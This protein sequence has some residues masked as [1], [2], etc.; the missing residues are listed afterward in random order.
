M[1]TLMQ[2]RH[3]GG[4]NGLRVSSLCLGTM[5]FGTRVSEKECFAVLDRF[6]EAGGN[7][8]DTANTYA[9]WADGATGAESEIV[10]GKWLQERG[11]RDEIV[12]ATK[13]GALPEPSG[14][15]WP[16]AAEGLSAEV[17]ARQVERSLTHLQTDWIDIYYAHIEDRATPAQETMAAFGGLVA[18]G[19]IRQFGCS[20]YAAW[21]IEEAQNAAAQQGMPG[22]TAVQQR[23]TYLQPKPGADFG[24]NPH[25]S[26][27]MLDYLRNRPE[28][29]LL[30][31]T[32]QLSGAYTDPHKE[33]PEQYRHEGSTA[34]LAALAEVAED[35]GV[36]K[37]QVV[38]S[39][40]AGAEPSVLP[41]I[42]ASTVAQ[43]EE[44]LG[45][46]DLELGADARARLDR[47]A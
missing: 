40:L 33:I 35:L 39:W 3:I 12:L 13:V 9:F 42:G 23:Y 24:V 27:E 45:A 46:V 6:H 11:V 31:Y 25:A 32:P 47:A 37:N 41:I 18:Q 2:Y 26:E 15:P 7:F 43:L 22:F 20:N 30:A 28:L 14:A 44:S 34:R 17:I 5:S 10:I 16:E 19:K 4:P 38:L 36:T 8:I 29:T 1:R 21:R